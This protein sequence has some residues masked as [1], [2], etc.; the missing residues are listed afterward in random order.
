MNIEIL[1]FVAIGF[2]AQI[3]DGALRPTASPPHLSLG[4]QF[5]PSYS[6]H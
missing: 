2:F 4:H 6:Q 3:V 1:S 5:V